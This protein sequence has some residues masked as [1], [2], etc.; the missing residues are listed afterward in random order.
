MTTPKSAAHAGLSRR[1]FLG[2]GAG[3]ASAA[4]TSAA[5]PGLAHSGSGARSSTSGSAQVITHINTGERQVCLTFDDLWSEYFTLKIGRAFFERGIRLTLFPIGIAVQNN[6]NRPN[7][8]YADLYPRLRD[9]GHEFGSHLFTHRPI[10]GFSVEQLIA[11]ELEPSLDVMRQALG[12]EF[13]PV[14]IRPP[15][16]IVTEEMKQVAEQYG[17][18]LI[19][20]GMDSQD[21]ICT[22]QQCDEQCIP[23]AE[24][25]ADVLL[26]YQEGDVPDLCF[27]ENCEER[28]VDTIISNYETYL[29]PGAIILHH[30]LKTSYLA[31]PRVMKLLRNWNMQPLPLSSFLGN[32][33]L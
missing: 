33:S 19:L 16:G 9:M 20:W 21:A 25:Q 31:I 8:G 18:P 3:L 30:A 29:R 2:L 26:R 10:H 12:R 4:L 23:E 28:C 7:Q 6:L 24:A 14:G 1:Q 27:Q 13:R 5:L 32:R 11:E 22:K 17:Y 15:Y